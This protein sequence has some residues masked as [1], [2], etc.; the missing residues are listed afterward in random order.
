MGI[1]K[2]TVREMY[3]IGFENTFV[4]SEI[5]R[6]FFLIHTFRYFIFFVQPLAVCEMPIILLIIGYIHPIHQFLYRG[7]INKLMYSQL[8]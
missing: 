7:S 2:F 5:R 4:A 8:E 3:F 1:K 6:Y